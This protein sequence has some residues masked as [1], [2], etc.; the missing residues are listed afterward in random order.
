MAKKPAPSGKGIMGRTMQY[1]FSP[2]R[3]QLLATKAF[4]AALGLLAAA[5]VVHAD[6]PPAL[7]KYAGHYK[8]AGT[9]EQGIA[10]VDKALNRPL[11]DVNIAMSY[12]IRKEFADHFVETISI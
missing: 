5:G 12:I 8:Y 6:T 2:R 7:A 9:R 11:Q 1:A 3:T 10:I 4:A